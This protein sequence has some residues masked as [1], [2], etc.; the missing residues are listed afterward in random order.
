MRTGNASSFEAALSDAGVVRHP[1]KL[2]SCVCQ[3]ALIKIDQQ[4]VP[5]YTKFKFSEELKEAVREPVEL[6]CIRLIEEFVPVEDALN[7]FSGSIPEVS[8][9]QSR[10]QIG[11][12]NWHFTSARETW[13]S[14]YSE[15]EPCY[16]IG[17]DPQGW[18]QDAPGLGGKAELESII[19]QSIPIGV[20][21]FF[22]C[23]EDAI[24]WWMGYPKAM[25]ISNRSPVIT[26][27]IIIPLCPGLVKEIQ[28]SIENGLEVI[29]SPG[30]PNDELKVSISAKKNG[31][32]YWP[33][34]I[35]ENNRVYFREI[36]QGNF[37]VHIE[38][39]KKSYAT[40][41]SQ[42]DSLGW[43]YEPEK[44]KAEGIIK[45]LSNGENEKCE[46]K[47]FGSPN[48]KYFKR[49]E[50]LTNIRITISGMA[51]SSGGHLL[52]GVDDYAQVV[53]IEPSIELIASDLK[54]EAHGVKDRLLDIIKK[55][56][57]DT[58]ESIPIY[59][60]EWV[61]IDSRFLLV[62][63]IERNSPDRV[64]KENDHTMY[65][66]RGGTTRR[67]SLDEIQT[68][69]NNRIAAIKRTNA[70]DR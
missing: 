21:I 13:F 60:C 64:T 51:N 44:D 32:Y 26:I 22:S 54:C 68:I 67:A 57:S 31:E 1:S 39:N 53:G 59:F 27:E 33:S 50:L 42:S 15:K 24:D 9:N 41:K 55:H 65:I 46:F 40:Y 35:P 20:D 61:E 49:E 23:I 45:L 38:L 8:I 28:C 30:I 10:R 19:R 48:G 43:R 37:V 62:F 56:I 4:W 18:I 70:S 17:I 52:I 5:F 11:S 63:K 69:L 29:L 58:L 6:D 66:R 36:P 7:W 47:L 34:K 12:Q 3:S 16:V 25:R 14:W 2:S